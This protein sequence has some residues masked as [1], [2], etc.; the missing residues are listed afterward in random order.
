MRD[1]EQYPD[2]MTTAEVAEATGLAQ[3][4]IRT[5]ITAGEL[6]YRQAGRHILVPKSVLPEVFAPDLA[7]ALAASKARPA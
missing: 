5:L 2:L 6:P 4:R 3:R 7:A 1:L